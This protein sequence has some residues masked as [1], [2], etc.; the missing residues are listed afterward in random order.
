MDPA[1]LFEPASIRGR[2][3]EN[4]LVM[5]PMQT[6]LTQDDGSVSDRLVAYLARRARGGTAMVMVE[7]AYVD[8]SWSAKADRAMMAGVVDPVV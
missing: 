8:D 6:H 3:R 1:P 5:A 4:R 2:T 7:Y